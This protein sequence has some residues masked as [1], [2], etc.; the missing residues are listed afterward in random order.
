MENIE[1]LATLVHGCKDCNIILSVRWVE[2][3]G[4]DA[5]RCGKD[6]KSSKTDRCKPMS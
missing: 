3:G 2:G 1:F 4:T 5:E 6:A